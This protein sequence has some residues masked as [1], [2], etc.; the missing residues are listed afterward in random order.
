MVDSSS[1]FAAADEKKTSWVRPART[2]A[3]RIT[4]V[5]TVVVR[6]V[7]TGGGL[8]RP[9]DTEKVPQNSR[10]YV[11]VQFFTDAGLIGTTMDGDYVLPD[12][13]GEII[14]Q[15]AQYF[16][17]K[18]P[19]EIE[20]HNRNFF[21]AEGYNAYTYGLGKIPT[22]LFFLEIGLWDIIGKAL[23]QPLY[24][25]WGA[26]RDKVQAY[27]ATVHFGKSP[28][29]RAEDA[30]AFYEHGFKA[31]KLRLHH[32]NPDDDLKLV[33]A[34][35]KA[36]GGKMKVMTDANMGGNKPGDPPPA[37]DFK[38]AERMAL[39]LQD[40]GVYWLEEALPLNDYDGLARIRRQ[41][42]SMYLAGGEGNVGFA[43]FREILRRDS[44]SYIQPDPMI[45]GPVS[46]IRKIA[47]MGEA[48][49]AKFGPHHGKSG[50]GMITNLHM[51]CAAPNSGFIEY[52]YD[53]GY[54]NPAGFQAGFAELYPL[55]KEGY[56][57]VP[58]LPGHGIQWDPEFF[59]KHGL[60]YQSPT[61]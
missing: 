48:F 38:V 25:L 8:I 57:H 47:A 43:Q 23:N 13:Y 5:K 24:R 26:A 56:M 46:V 61:A 22:R 35:I 2:P 3:I 36:A 54:W 51:Q 34:V 6:K 20:V 16:V 40:L 30:L 4:G 50:V 45:G 41:L 15:K 17:G 19:F 58:K 60:E 39:A 14:N 37:W 29:E 10:D 59:R 33:A 18:D 21:E 1:S 31:V 9:W 27:A 42:K 32:M 12:D 53:P 28:E 55:D 11:I 49:G 7:P 52:M 44:L